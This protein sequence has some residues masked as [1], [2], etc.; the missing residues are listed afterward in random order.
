MNNNWAN[1]LFIYY[2][3]ILQDIFPITEEADEDEKVRGFTI[4]ES[5][6][7][8]TTFRATSNISLVV[9]VIAKRLMYQTVDI[10]ALFGPTAKD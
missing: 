9:G 10:L 1:I 5:T 3:P 7:Q 8:L 2:S 4:L 6:S